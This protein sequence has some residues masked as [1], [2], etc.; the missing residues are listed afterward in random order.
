[1]I[2][3]AWSITTNDYGAVSGIGDGPNAPIGFWNGSAPGKDATYAVENLDKLI[4]AEVTPDLILLNFGHT[5]D[6]KAPLAEQVRPLLN[7]LRK[8]YPSAEFVAIKQSPTQAGQTNALM[9]GYNSAMDSEGV[10]VIDVYSAFP[11]ETAA[12]RS[13]LRDAVNP[14]RAG[15]DL[16]SATVLK[17]FG[18]QQG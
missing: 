14:N 6:P 3:R 8:E 12:L 10:Q 16:W 17:A 1:M 5:L 13:L 2:T 9:P 15:Q 7:N 11:S 18:L 4:P